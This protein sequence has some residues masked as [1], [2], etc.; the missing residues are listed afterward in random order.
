MNAQPDGRQFRHVGTRPVRPDGI[1]KV[2]GK[3]IYGPDF[4][5]P[6]MLF[7][8]ILRSPHPHARIRA[9]DT[10]KAAALPGVN[11][12]YTYI[13]DM[14]VMNYLLIYHVFGLLWTTQFIQGI[15]AMTVAG[16]V[17]GWYFSQ[18]PDA[19]KG[20]AEVEKSVY[21]QPKWPIAASLRRTLSAD[22]VCIARSRSLAMLSSR[23][24]AC[25]FRTTACNSRRRAPRRFS[26][27][28]TRS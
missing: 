9:I 5:A 18:V 11:A 10:K 14:P 2:T 17:C 23:R 8:A 26:R 3:A 6:G 15:A 27:S 19:N 16:A 25:C 12:T 1:D 21:V 4:V 28:F 7:G 24:W 13:A 22:A 20:V